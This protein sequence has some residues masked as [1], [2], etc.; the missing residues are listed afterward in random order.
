MRRAAATRALA[1]ELG[2]EIQGGLSFFRLM[3]ERLSQGQQLDAE[4]LTALSE[5]LARFSQLG[6]QLREFARTP[7]ARAEH[8]PRAVLDAACNLVTSLPAPLPLELT[9]EVEPDV[10]LN[11]D[12]DVLAQGLAELL[13]NALEAR[14]QRAGVK[15]T[16]DEAV[17]FCVWDDGPGFEQGVER[18]LRW[19]V[20]SR[21]G[22][23]GLGLTLALRSARAH[24]YFVQL[25]REAGLTLVRLVVPARDVLSSRAKLAP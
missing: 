14:A 7:L 8:T 1:A 3:A 16:I 21:P 20:T 12:I 2:H 17:T 10:R 5:E 9:L 4:E 25:E 19:G 22:A 15:V 23:L 18:A 13:D 24:G 11:C 6:G